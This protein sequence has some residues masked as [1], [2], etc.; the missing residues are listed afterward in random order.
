MWKI[1]ELGVFHDFLTIHLGV[2][3][4]FRTFCAC[5]AISRA[6]E[7]SRSQEAQEQKWLREK[8][9]GQ[10]MDRLEEYASSP[11]RRKGQNGE[12]EKQAG[13]ELCQAQ[14]SLIYPLAVA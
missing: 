10:K 9:R 3:G 13:A 5:W 2:L 6:Q 1:A 4:F 8:W 7:V 12:N 14:C 11:S